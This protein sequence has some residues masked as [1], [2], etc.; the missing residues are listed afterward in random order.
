MFLF[1]KIF[2]KKNKKEITSNKLV[3]SKKNEINKKFDMLMIHSDLKNLLW[4]ADGEYKNYIPKDNNQSFECNGVRIT[5]SS[6][7]SQEPSLISLKSTITEIDDVNSIEK[8][9]Y[10]PSY[11]EITN[12]QRGVYWKFLQQPY[13][14]KFN[15]GYVFILYYGL[16]R[17]LLEGDFENAFNVILKLRDVHDNNSFQSY[18]G[19]AIILTCLRFRRPDLLLEFYNSLDKNYEFNF[20]NNLYL[21]CC[22]YLEIPITPI[23]IIR[24]AKTFEFTNQ[25]YIKKHP[26]MFFAHLCEIMQSTIKTQELYISKYISNA[27][28]KKLKNEK[29][30]IFCN[31]TLQNNHIDVPLVSENF[32]LKK[33]VNNL[34]EQTHESVKA[35]LVVMRKKGTAPLDNETKTKKVVEVLTFDYIA[36]KDLLNKYKNSTGNIMNQ[37]FALIALYDFYYKYRDLDSKHI[38]TCISYCLDDIALLSK[39]QKY[40]IESEKRNIL[41]RTKMYTK[42]EIEEQISNI[43]YM[44][45]TIPAF[46]RLAIIYEKSKQ[47]EEVIEICNKAIAYYSSVTMYGEVEE[48]EKRKIKVE[49]KMRKNK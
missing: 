11:A 17:Q 46:K 45:G 27:E 1:D 3:I 7:S 18:S 29:T 19:N 21:I 31:I 12:E 44:K 42:R 48:F 28:R 14:D 24:M 35:E 37:H 39:L 4:I 36:E 8:P 15:I 40:H 25:N 9:P 26:D 6:F 23:D 38:E 20:S 41:E 47:Y 13:D 43:T 2:G 10:F 5:F 34:L 30:P 32:K 49:N 16:E 22:F 33:I